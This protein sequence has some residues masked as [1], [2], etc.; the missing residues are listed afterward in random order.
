MTNKDLIL[1]ACAFAQVFIKE[2]DRASAGLPSDT[3]EAAAQ[4]RAALSQLPYAIEG[5]SCNCVEFHKP[6]AYN[7]GAK[8]FEP[9]TGCRPLDAEVDRV[10]YYVQT[11]EGPKLIGS[12]PPDSTTF[13]KAEELP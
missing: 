5:C 6:R 4:L 1:Q 12:M 3:H 9:E 2:A 11:P 7:F 8:Q 10:D 13:T